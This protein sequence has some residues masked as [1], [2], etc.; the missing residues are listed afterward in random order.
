MGGDRLDRAGPAGGDRRGE[1]PP[2]ARGRATHDDSARRPLTPLL[3]P[4]AKRNGGGHP[5]RPRL[6]ASSSLLAPFERK[7]K[8]CTDGG[9]V[10]VQ[11][12]G[13]GNEA[14]VRHLARS[15]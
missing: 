4:R 13:G 3:R 8:G 11:P 7:K 15:R 2:M 9:L 14:C 5:D 1:V 6:G 12:G 10:S